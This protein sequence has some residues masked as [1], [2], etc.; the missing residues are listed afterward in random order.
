MDMLNTK[1]QKGRPY[2]H[3][4]KHVLSFCNNCMQMAP[5]N[6]DEQKGK[7]YLQGCAR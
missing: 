1:Q 2:V 7:R 6:I 4:Y 3:T 5:E